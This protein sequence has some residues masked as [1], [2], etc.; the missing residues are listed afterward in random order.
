M[1]HR[2]AIAPGLRLKLLSSLP[3]FRAGVAP[4]KAGDIAHLVPFHH[5][6]DRDIDVVAQQL[7]AR[8]PV[9]TLGLGETA[10]AEPVPEHAFKTQSFVARQDVPAFRNGDL[11]MPAGFLE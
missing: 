6:Q 8:G 7:M 10:S 4:A 11:S 1:M 5:V 3:R 9:Q 2:V